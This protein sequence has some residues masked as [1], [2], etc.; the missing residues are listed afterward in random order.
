MSEVCN[1]VELTPS[2]VRQVGIG[3]VYLRIMHEAAGGAELPEITEAEAGGS[4]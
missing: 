1:A 2:M 4:T 3:E